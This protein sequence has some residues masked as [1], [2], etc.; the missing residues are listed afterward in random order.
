MRSSDVYVISGAACIMETPAAVIAAAE[1]SGARAAAG[2]LTEAGLSVIGYP[3]RSCD[4]LNLRRL[5]QARSLGRGG[6]VFNTTRSDRRQLAL[7]LW[8]SLERG[9]LALSGN[10][11]NE[12]LVVVALAASCASGVAGRPH[13]HCPASAAFL[14]P[15]LVPV[16][17]PP[18]ATHP[19]VGRNTGAE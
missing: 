16:V 10:Q 9:S 15:A 5:S 6:L 3:L 18:V 13:R 12:R 17:R 4:K 19:A 8:R 2:L 7:F 14:P 11:T 1:G